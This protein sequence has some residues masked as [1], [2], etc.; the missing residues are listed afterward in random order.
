MAS[1]SYSEYRQEFPSHFPIIYI[2]G[3][4]VSDIVIN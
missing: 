1:F 3:N 2:A 4:D